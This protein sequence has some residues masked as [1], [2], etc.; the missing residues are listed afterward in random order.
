MIVFYDRLV[1]GN[2]EQLYLHQMKSL[3]FL[4]LRK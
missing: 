3:F 1:K 4:G 2:S